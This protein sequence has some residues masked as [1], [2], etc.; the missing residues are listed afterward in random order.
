M[1][2]SSFSASVCNC[3]PLLGNCRKWPFD[4]RQVTW[5]R[6]VLLSITHAGSHAGSQSSL[7]LSLQFG[8]QRQTAVQT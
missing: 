2:L 5:L 7:A 3:F 8:V 1:A 6:F 4:Q